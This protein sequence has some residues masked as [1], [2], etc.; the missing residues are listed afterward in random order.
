MGFLNQLLGG[1]QQQQDYQGYLQRYEQGQPS[2]GYSDEEVMNRYQQ[3]AP[4]LSQNQYMQAAEAAF[5]HMTPQQRAEFGQVLE[6]QARQR[7][8]NIPGM[9]QMEGANRFQDAGFLAQLTGQLH[10]QQPGLLGQLLGGASS[11]SSSSGGS[12]LSNPAVKAGLAGIA[13]MAVKH[14]LGGS[15]KSGGIL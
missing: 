6:Q 13:A 15:N 11:G 10:Q 5:N 3:V 14:F 12:L 2:E 7:G 8:V 4:H 1:G 9:N